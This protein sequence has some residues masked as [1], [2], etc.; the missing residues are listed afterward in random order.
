[1]ALQSETG[2]TDARAAL[3]AVSRAVSRG[4][5]CLEVIA[6]CQLADRKKDLPDW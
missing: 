2:I 5:Y 4:V 3:L 1:M 6:A